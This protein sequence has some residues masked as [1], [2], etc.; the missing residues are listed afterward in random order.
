[1][2]K[3][4]NQRV[5]VVLLIIA[6]VYLFL[7]YQ[8]PPYAY[9]EVEAD[10]VPKTLGWLLVLLSVFLFFS[11]D[12]ET[13]EQKARRSISGSEI[14]VL[15]AVFGFI[16]VYIL[17]LEKVGFMIMTAL[18]IF[19]CS[20]FLG[21]KKYFTNMTVSIVFSISMYF[22]FVKL[23]RISLPQGILPF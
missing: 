18:F 23:L 13:N 7:S 8:I 11:K 22:M 21:Y 17:F 10:V 2:F 16:L 12:T 19:F 6:C 20:W 14:G 9:T 3:N 4:I 15:I 5:S 1:M